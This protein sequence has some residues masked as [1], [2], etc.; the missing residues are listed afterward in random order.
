MKIKIKIK[1]C[2]RTQ[3]CP[4]KAWLTCGWEGRRKLVVTM[5]YLSLSQLAPLSPGTCHEESWTSV[6]EVG[7][8]GQG[9]EGGG[10]RQLSQSSQVSTAAQR[11]RPAGQPAETVSVTTLTPQSVSPTV[12]ENTEY[13]TITTSHHIITTS[14]QHHYHTTTHHHIYVFMSGLKYFKVLAIWQLF[15]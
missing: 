2:M 15:L 9:E 5:D 8:A 1:N 6:P 10:R 7:S 3:C 4:G 11:E 14:L 12:W 13:H